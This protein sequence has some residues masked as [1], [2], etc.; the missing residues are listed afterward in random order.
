MPKDRK[1]TYG[2]ICVNYRPQKADPYRTR[3]TVGGDRIDYPWDKSCPTAGL[4]TSKILFNS[5]VSTKNAKFFG[6]DIAHFYLCTPLDRY[7]YMQLPIGIIP[8]EIIDQY[9]L[10]ELENDGKVYIEIQKG[11]YGLPQAGILANNLLIERL[12]AFGYYPVEFTPG[13]WRH[14]WRPI[15]FSLVVDDFGVK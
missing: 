2:R 15:V 5:V 1:V 10:R 13:L 7:E 14:K 11:M 3:L 4:Q 8:D 12:D 6:I 9:N